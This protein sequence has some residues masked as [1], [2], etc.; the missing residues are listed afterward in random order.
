MNAYAQGLITKEDISRCAV[1]VFTTRYLLGILGDEGSEYDAIPYETI[2]CEEHLA[3]AH[4]AALR[5]CVLLKNNGLLPLDPAKCGTIGV[6]GPNANSRVC[7]IGNYHGTASRYVTVLEGIQDL[8]KGKCRVLYS[9]GCALSED[10][11]EPL[12]QPND[13]LA[14]AAAVAKHSDTVILVLGLDETLEGEEGDTGN[15]YYSGDKADLLLPESQRIL[16]RHVLEIGKPTVVVLLAGSAIDLSEAQ[17]SADAILLG[18]YPGAGGGR[19]VAE[20]LFG[21]ESPSGKLPLTF[22]RNAALEEMPAFT[23]YSMKGRTYR[24]YQGSPLYPFGY[25]LSYGTAALSLKEAGRGGAAVRVK[26]ESD[27]AL[28]EVVELY[29]KDEGSPL[30][31]PKASLCGFQR[32]R[33]EAGEEKEIFIPIGEDAFTVVDEKGERIPGSGSWRLWAGFGAPDARTEELTGRKAVTA[34]IE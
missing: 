25:G 21:K 5:S 9:E 12:A 15:S 20:L 14:E 31:P 30:A 27:R 13:R 19:A 16:L 8:T 34:L 7:L 28:E 6:I 10:R 4:A 17:E 26:N 18:W 22:Y 29:L 3:L 33:L 2:E 11:V 1:R 24:Y 32:I 23:D